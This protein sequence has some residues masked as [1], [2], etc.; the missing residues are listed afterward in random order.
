VIT[1]QSAAHR[2]IVASAAVSV[3]S[4]AISLTGLGLLI[5]RQATNV[6]SRHEVALQRVLGEVA[7]GEDAA[8]EA[9]LSRDAGQKAVADATTTVTPGQANVDG[10]RRHLAQLDRSRDALDRAVRQ[11]RD[12]A[13]QN[14]GAD[15]DKILFWRLGDLD[16]ALDRVSLTDQLSIVVETERLVIDGTERLDDV[17]R[18]GPQS[19]KPPVAAVAPPAVETTVPPA[20]P[21][22]GPAPLPAPRQEAPPPAAADAPTPPS[23]QPPSAA[24]AGSSKLIAAQQTFDRFGFTSVSYGPGVAEDHYAATDLD[25]QHIY[26]DLGRIPAARVTSVCI[27]EYMHILQARAYGGRAGTIAHFGSVAAM[28]RDADRMALLNGATWT[29][30][31]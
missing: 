21:A 29:H 18:P 8:K 2:V 12:A 16:R 15:I 30:Y 20:A 10:V 24:P 23:A 26:V 28:E 5:S 22:P 3:A 17:P 6:N 31:L 9:Q 27:H 4:A 7:T 13:S 14:A 25:A 11:A 1:R 19:S